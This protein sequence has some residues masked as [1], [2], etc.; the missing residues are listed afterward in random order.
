[1]ISIWSTFRVI[2][3]F[4]GI[5]NS[6]QLAR[7]RGCSTSTR[8]Q[9]I[10]KVS[11]LLTISDPLFRKRSFGVDRERKLLQATIGVL[12]NF[13]IELRDLGCYTEKEWPCPKAYNTLLSI[14]LDC[15]KFVPV[16]LSSAIS[17]LAIQSSTYYV[18]KFLGCALTLGS[19]FLS[20]F[21]CR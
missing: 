21:H 19:F 9:Y 20:G 16:S 6:E 17:L 5:Y 12:A 10:L 2:Q 14:R 15:G 4:L 13:R 18:T 3:R 11:S 7:C 1:M 8:T